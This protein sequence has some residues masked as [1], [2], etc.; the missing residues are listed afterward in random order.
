MRKE[1][2]REGR[3]EGKVLFCSNNYIIIN[4]KFFFNIKN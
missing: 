4:G 3:E 2:L 1:K